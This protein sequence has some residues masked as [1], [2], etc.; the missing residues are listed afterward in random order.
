MTP[1]FPLHPGKYALRA[2]TDPTEHAQHVR[3]QYP[4]ATLADVDGVVLLHQQDVLKQA[5]TRYPSRRVH[6]V[7]GELFILKRR[8]R[9]VAVCGGFGL[10]APAATLVL[11]Q[12]IAL[13]ARRVI[14][15]GTA[16]TLRSDLSPGQ[17]VIC[18]NALRDE[19]VSHHYLPPGSHIKASQQLTRDLAGSLR[20]RGVD[21][22]RG[23][24]WT[25]DALYRETSAEVSRYGGH[26]VLTADMEAAAVFAVAKYRRI[27]AAA[28]FAVADSLVE[29]QTRHGQSQVGVALHTA[30][31]AALSAVGPAKVRRPQGDEKTTGLLR[32]HQQ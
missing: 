24:S 20:A 23:P 29:R 32:P 5:V 22:R 30:V 8:D 7:R 1:P 17:L 19:G 21:A 31:E 4:K 13:G 25:T 28:V 27:D 14:T 12:L 3:G 11:E 9:Q 16:A 6:W 2:V 26:G 10:G 18:D 15:V